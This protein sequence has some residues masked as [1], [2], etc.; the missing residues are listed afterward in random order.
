MGT[1]YGA[2]EQV[3]EQI[4]RVASSLGVSDDMLTSNQLSLVV[5]NIRTTPTELT[6]FDKYYPLDAVLDPTSVIGKATFEDILSAVGVSRTDTLQSDVKTLKAQIVA[7]Q[8]APQTAAKPVKPPKTP[9]IAPTAGGDSVST[10]TTGTK[11][12]NGNLFVDARVFK[13]CFSATELG[14]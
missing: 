3:G 4:Y 10:L 11:Q 14:S 9:A 7:L 2:F 5:A 8:T 1:V 6:K 12:P 13:Q